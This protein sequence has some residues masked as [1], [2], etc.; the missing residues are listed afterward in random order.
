MHGQMN[1]WTDGQPR[2]HVQRPPPPSIE[3]LYLSASLAASHPTLLFLKLFI[4]LFGCI[5]S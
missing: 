1:T 3:V 4:Y 2:G 5:R